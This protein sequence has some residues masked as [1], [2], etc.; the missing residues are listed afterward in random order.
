MKG[1]DYLVIP[2]FFI[3]FLIEYMEKQS[4]KQE[5]EYKGNLAEYQTVAKNLYVK[6]EQDKFT[7]YQNYLYKRALYGLNGMTQEELAKTC[8][9]KKHRINKVYVK[10]QN[11]INLYKQKLTIGY[12]NILFKTLFPNSPI[13][14]YLLNDT[15]T[16][17]NFKN[18]LNFK[19][20]NIKK[21]DIIRIFIESGV[22]P[23]NF[24]SLTN[25]PNELPRLKN[26][27]L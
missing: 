14:D 21:D 27:K 4:R 12:T 18:T 13:T 5:F 11:V 9:K 3:F 26:Q 23:K 15:D 10:G 25:N 22:L 17:V 24:M 2:L 1:D 20:L 19:D 6:Y 8:E 16:D 7:A